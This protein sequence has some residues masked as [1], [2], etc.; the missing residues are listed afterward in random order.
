MNWHSWKQKRTICEFNGPLGQ[1][2]PS[3][4]SQP[5]LTPR[6]PMPPTPTM[7]TRPGMSSQAPQFEQVKDLFISLLK[8]QP[9]NEQQKVIEEI[10]QEFGPDIVQLPDSNTF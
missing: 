8:K 10:Q 3:G 6:T 1:P 5:M 4:V 7:G 9:K 2:D